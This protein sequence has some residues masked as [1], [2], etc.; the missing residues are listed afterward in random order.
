MGSE[1]CI[2]DRYRKGKVCLSVL[3]TW[4]G[5]QWTGCQTISSVL[6]SLRANVLAVAEPLL[7]EPG[8]TKAHRDFDRYHR[9]VEFKNKQLAVLGAANHIMNGTSKLCPEL[10]RAAAAHLIGALPRAKAAVYGLAASC[11]V[12]TVVTTIYSMKASID[13]PALAASID[14][15]LDR[16]L[17]SLRQIRQID[18]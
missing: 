3:N 14:Q 15:G 13:Y 18:V 16:L 4:Q 2:R 1:M 11:P 17:A 6:L 8:V 5:P 7:N 10:Q 12:E 9:I